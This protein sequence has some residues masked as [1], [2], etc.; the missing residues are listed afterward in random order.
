VTGR[1]GW[2]VDVDV[3]ADVGGFRWTA[4]FGAPGVPEVPGSWAQP[5][6]IT[7]MKAPIKRAERPA[8]RAAFG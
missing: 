4:G 1:G 7:T 3:L 8:V 5:A 6:R 2:V